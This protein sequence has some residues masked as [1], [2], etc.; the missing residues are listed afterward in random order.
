MQQIKKVSVAKVFGKLKIADL[1]A[2]KN[3]DEFGDLDVMQVVGVAVGT[4]AGESDYG[5]WLALTGDFEATNPKTGEV[6]RSAICFVPD[7]ALTPIQVGLAQEGARGVRFAIMVTARFNEDVSTKY[8]YGFRPLIP[9]AADDPIAQIKAQMLAL[10]DQSSHTA[11]AKPG[12]DL[13]DL[14]PEQ[15]VARSNRKQNVPAKKARR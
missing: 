6:F 7:V 9:A 10:T 11:E 15:L 2:I 14:T 13:R 5:D 4:K 12:E 8:E 3:G 1:M